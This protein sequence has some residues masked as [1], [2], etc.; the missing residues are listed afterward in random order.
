MPA[1]HGRRGA[2]RARREATKPSHLR[3]AASHGFRGRARPPT[4]EERPRAP[5]RARRGCRGRGASARAPRRSRKRC[6]FPRAVS[7]PAL[8]LINHFKMVKPHDALEA[9]STNTF[10]ACSGDFD[11]V[12][13]LNK[14]KITGVVQTGMCSKLASASALRPTQ[15][16]IGATI[17]EACTTVCADW[18]NLGDAAFF[19]A[20]GH[21]K[22]GTLFGTASSRLLDLT[23]AP[24][25]DTPG[26]TV[27]VKT[28]A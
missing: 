15:F 18:P 20:G 25:A 22:C 4:P 21:L 7:R 24:A 8:S 28:L 27:A 10:D 14:L 6:W 13:N 17:N 2:A 3:S 23:G 9:S 11:E 19:V 12:V 26:R 16:D 5:L 1:R